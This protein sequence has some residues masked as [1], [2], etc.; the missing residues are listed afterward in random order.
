MDLSWGRAGGLPLGLCGGG[1]AQPREA[2]QSA[3][4][5]DRHQVVHGVPNSVD[6]A[7]FG[8]PFEV[9]GRVSKEEGGGVD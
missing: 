8:D 9:G 5:H 3:L 4:A 2:Q 7:G 6:V 1:G